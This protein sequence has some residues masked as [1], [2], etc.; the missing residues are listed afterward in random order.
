MH[1]KQASVTN[2]TA[3]SEDADNIVFQMIRKS[4]VSRLNVVFLISSVLLFINIHIFN[5]PDPRL[6]GLFCLV[7]TSPDNQGSTVL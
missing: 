1:N 7:P 2:V 4:V 3:D 5:Y 6:S